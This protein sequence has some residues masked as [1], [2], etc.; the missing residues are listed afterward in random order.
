[1]LENKI[2]DFK[3]AMDTY[4]DRAIYNKFGIGI[5]IA[6]VSMQLTSA[7]NLLAHFC[8]DYSLGVVTGLFLAYMMADLLSGLTHM[9]MDNNTNY[10]S[11]V[12]PFIAAFH[13]HH[14]QPNYKRKNPLIVYFMESGTKF[15]LVFYLGIVIYLQYTIDLPLYLNIF[16]V[17]LGIF[18]SLAEVSHYWCHNAGENNLIVRRLQK[19]R[20]LLSKKHHWYHHNQDNTNYAFLNGMTDPI[21]NITAR[22]LYSGYKKNSD[23]HVL[24]YE[25]KQTSNRD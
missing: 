23:V 3:I 20:I 15:W 6:I 17:A 8:V 25:G 24:A 11:I 10:T 9:Y 19:C 13:M 7:V 5:S 4:N 2:N 16:L 18:S 21:I 14:K 1:M 12:G 22:Y